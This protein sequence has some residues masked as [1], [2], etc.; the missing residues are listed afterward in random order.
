[1]AVQKGSKSR[2]GS[3]NS[4]VTVQK[5]EDLLGKSPDCVRTVGDDVE[6][7]RCEHEYYQT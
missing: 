1:M 5:N 2:L 7:E 6:Y 4:Q 3:M